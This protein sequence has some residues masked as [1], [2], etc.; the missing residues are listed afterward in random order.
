M[1][2]DA[3]FHIISNV[4]MAWQPLN[5]ATAQLHALYTYP[6]AVNLTQAWRA[7]NLQTSWECNW[8]HGHGTK[9]LL[10]F[11]SFDFFQ[12]LTD[13]LSNVENGI[14]IA[15]MLEVSINIDISHIN[16]IIINN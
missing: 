16:A 15:Q 12:K 10:V 2:V 1:G 6:L 11:E 9:K 8:K 7:L 14:N 4:N 13:A 3:K 5:I